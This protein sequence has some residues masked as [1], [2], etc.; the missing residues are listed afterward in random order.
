MDR[1]AFIAIMGGRI[2][3]RRQRCAESL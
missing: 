2:V 3:V 1:L